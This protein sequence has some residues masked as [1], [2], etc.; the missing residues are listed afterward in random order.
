MVFK[1]DSESPLGDVE[2]FQNHVG[3]STDAI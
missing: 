2:C 1:V 3:F